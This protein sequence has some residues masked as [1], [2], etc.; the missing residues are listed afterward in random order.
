MN[1]YISQ[2]AEKLIQPAVLD[3]Y[4]Q[5]KKAGIWLLAKI[6]YRMTLLDVS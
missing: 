6:F 4:S 1:K 3:Q 5:G 2:I